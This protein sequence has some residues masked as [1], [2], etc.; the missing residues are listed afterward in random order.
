[1]IRCTLNSSSTT[2]V[3]GSYLLDA[4]SSSEVGTINA[5]V[6]FL[7]GYGNDRCIQ[8][9]PTDL[10]LTIMEDKNGA[11]KVD[12]YIMIDKF[13][14]DET[15][16]FK[17]PNWLVQN[18]SGLKDYAPHI[19]SELASVIPSSKALT[20]CQ[21]LSSNGSTNMRYFVNGIISAF[22]V[23]PEDIARY[24]VA[25]FDISD[26]GITNNQLFC[27]GVRYLQNSD[28]TTGD[29]IAIGDKVVIYGQLGN[30]YTY[31]ALINGY[32]YD[33]TA[34]LVEEEKEPIVQEVYDLLGRKMSAEDG[35]LP[36]VYIVRQGDAVLKIYIH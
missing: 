35:Y 12:L 21:S 15:I 4:T 23:S 33:H 16:T 9:Q 14:I 22:R 1:M 32:V 3:V 18:G 10:Q 29:E 30:N 24:K 17:T 11:I 5:D 6:T 19:T 20:I 31:G 34:A 8:Y 2:S 27:Y 25:R 36:G 26:D 28:F 13:E 7:A